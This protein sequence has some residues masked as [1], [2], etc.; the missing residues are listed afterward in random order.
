M[1]RHKPSGPE[2]EPLGMAA[3]SLAEWENPPFPAPMRPHVAVSRN[4]AA[5][6]SLCARNLENSCSIA[7]AQT[8]TKAL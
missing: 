6:H 3:V 1:H 2:N 8:G 4:I 7:A 5:G